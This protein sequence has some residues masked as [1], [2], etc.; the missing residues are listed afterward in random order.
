[1][2]CN[3]VCNGYVCKYV[4]FVFDN[5]FDSTVCYFLSNA[6][7]YVRAAECCV[8]VCAYKRVI[9]TQVVVSML[10]FRRV[11][12]CQCKRAHL[13]A[14]VNDIVVRTCIKLVL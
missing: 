2:N 9:Y 8:S 4:M 1:M 7:F 3:V 10:I 14:L 6:Y 5:D 13:Y 11:C 12:M